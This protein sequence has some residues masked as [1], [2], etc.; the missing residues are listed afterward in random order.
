[1][2]FHFGHHHHQQQQQQQQQNPSIIY[3]N[4]NISCNCL[5]LQSVSG[6]NLDNKA[7]HKNND[8][9]IE[10]EELV[11][12]QISVTISVSNNSRKIVRNISVKQISPIVSYIQRR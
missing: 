12:R 10:Q 11:P 2:K 3:Q 9:N 8:I 5:S 6:L 4:I 1:M 7:G